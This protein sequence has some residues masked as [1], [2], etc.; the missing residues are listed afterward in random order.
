[1][2]SS[3]GTVTYRNLSDLYILGY[4]VYL[5]YIVGNMELDDSLPE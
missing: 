2:R 3:G 5:M 4:I 1:M